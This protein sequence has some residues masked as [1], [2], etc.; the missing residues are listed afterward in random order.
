L[1]K[2]VEFTGPAV[3]ALSMDN[4]FTMADHGVEI[5][6]KFA[7]FAYD[8]VTEAFLKPRA[9]LPYTPVAAD[10]DATYEQTI[11]VDLTGMAPQISAPHSFG[12]VQ[13]IEHL[14]GVRID[15]ACVG[16]CANGRF[17]D[18]EITARILKGRK[19]SKGVRLLVSAA[20][21]DIYRQCLDAGLPQIIIDAGGQFLN[22]GCGVC[23]S[24]QAYLAPGETCIT[25]TTRNYQGRMGSTEA[26]IY[27]GSPA[28]VTWSAVMG[29][30]ADPRDA[31]N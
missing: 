19:V 25:A 2:S 6:A 20:S 29:T 8:S 13:P 3:A 9:T 23:G 27:L 31:L 5:G 7:I 21:W 30:V 26:S 28:T 16:S 11:T 1:Y 17:E 10:D 4:R 14:A 22:P 18:I 15:Q 12:N 24:K